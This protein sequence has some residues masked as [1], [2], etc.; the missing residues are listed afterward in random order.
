MFIRNLTASE[1]RTE[2]ERTCVGRLAFV[3]DGMPQIVPMRFS[4]DGSDLYGFSMLGQKIECMR[5][6]PCVCVEFDDRTNHYQWM[7]VIATGLYEELA[8]SP[9]NIV[10][11]RHAQ[12]VLQRLAMWWQPATVATEA[13]NVFVPIFFRI[14]VKSMT[15]RQ[16]A[17]DPVEAI[18]LSPRESAVVRSGAIRNF[19]SE[20]MHLS[21]RGAARPK[22]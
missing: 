3:R 14:R 7:S 10:A 6:N 9:E 4:Y 13:R 21:R 1:C 11:R 20:V 16:A 15:G 2:L 12:A 5:E 22:H 18:Q 17:P 19:L 8:E